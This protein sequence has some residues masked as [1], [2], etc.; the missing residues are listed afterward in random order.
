MKTAAAQGSPVSLLVVDDSPA[1]RDVIRAMLEGDGGIRIVGE[2]GTGREAVEMARKMRPAVI[3]MDLQMPEMDGIEATERIMSERAVPIIAFSSF[4]WGGE[5]KA[6]IEMMAAG[7]LDVMAK[8]DLGGDGS[9]RECSE[10]LRRKIRTAS[11][12]AVVRHLRRS[13]PLPGAGWKCPGPEEGRTY[14]VLGVG[15]STGGPAALRELFSGLPAGFP[16]PVLVVQHITR[17]FTEGFVEWLRQH[18]PLAVR[19]AEA[20]DRAVPGTI[21]LAPE[22][23]QLEVLP[24]GEVRAVSREPSGVH[25]PSADTLLSSIAVSCG[26]SGIGVLLTGMGADGVEGLLAIRRAGGLTLAQNE[27]TCAVYGMPREAVRRGAA[28][29]VMSPASMAGLLCRLAGDGARNGE[30]DHG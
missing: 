28:L 27:G 26:K 29:Q 9:L 3:L 24:G 1:V 23:R 21:L 16:L 19:V 17:G 4:T 5:A 18:T 25:L 14:K 20:H 2:A 30:G 10:T 13:V 12:V 22:G 8:P 11:R 7:A 15:A 6:S